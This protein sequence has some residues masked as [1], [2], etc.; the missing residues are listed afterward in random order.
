MSGAN[1]KIKYQLFLDDERWP[2]PSLAGVKLLVI[3]R[4]YDAFVSTVQQLGYPEFIYFD[5]DL[6]EPKEGKDCAQWLLDRIID[7]RELNGEAVPDIGWAVHSQNSAVT[8]EID[9]KMGDII[10]YKS[11]S[12]V[13][14]T[15]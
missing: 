10:R 5:N 4:N 6:G 12:Q 8:K 1:N 2:G 13:E 3:C 7:R 9:K 11:I 15:D 14:K